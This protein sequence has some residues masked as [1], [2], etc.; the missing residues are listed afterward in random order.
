[1]NSREE[2]EAASEIKVG[3]EHKLVASILKKLIHVPD[4]KSSQAIEFVSNTSVQPV[5]VKFSLSMMKKY[6]IGSSD[7]LGLIHQFVMIHGDF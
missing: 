1:M 2:S 3:S 7:I 5:S 4:L 6:F